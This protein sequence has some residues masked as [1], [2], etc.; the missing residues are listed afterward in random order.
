[1]S[2]STAPRLNRN[3]LTVVLVMLAVV[4]WVL[5]LIISKAVLGTILF[6]N[7]LIGKKRAIESTLSDNI[8][9]T[10]DIKNS[11]EGL[12]DKDLPSEKVLRSLPVKQ[13]VPGLAS[14]LEAL[15]VA[16]N[17]SF[18]SFAL[19]STGEV[20]ETDDATGSAPVTEGL[21]EYTFTIKVEGAYGS[22]IQMLL[23]FERE[24][25]PMR[26]MNVKV[27]GT[28]QTASAEIMIKAYFQPPVTLDFAKEEIK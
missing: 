19:E 17:V 26:L 3:Q 22:I 28:E 4:V 2:A 21:Q 6:N 25:A 8:S 10:D 20:S 15:L 13:D 14:K 9:K 1:M 11:F 12:A 7:R 16:S 23:N 27:E 24:I 5:G 18:K